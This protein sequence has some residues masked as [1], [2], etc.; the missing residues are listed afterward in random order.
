MMHFLLC[1]FIVDMTSIFI[2]NVSFFFKVSQVKNGLDFQF[3]RTL[4]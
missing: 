2:G 1:F 3:F 4:I